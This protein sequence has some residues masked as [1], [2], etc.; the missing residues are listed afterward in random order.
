MPDEL[1]LQASTDGTLS[2]QSPDSSE[3]PTPIDFNR[4]PAYQRSEHKWTQM[5]TKWTSSEPRLLSAC[6]A[7]HSGGQQA[8]GNDKH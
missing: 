2:I 1:Q 5:N 6:L 4:K 8:D 3:H 7:D